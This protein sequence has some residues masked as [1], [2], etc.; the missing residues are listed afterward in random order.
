MLQGDLATFPLAELFQWLDQSRRTGVLEL[1]AGEGPPFWLHVVDRRIV[2]AAGTDAGPEGLGSLARWSH[3]EPLESLWP[4]ACADRIVDLFLGPSAGRFTLVA[5]AAGYDGVRLDLGL[6]QMAL[7]GMRRLDEWPALDRR[8]P[9]DA[10]VLVAD[11]PAA[12]PRTPGQRALLEAAR[13]RASIAEAR[14]ALGL[15]RAAVLR[16]IAALGDLGLAHV[17]GVSAHP[18]PVATLV[19]KAQLLVEARQ[20]DEAAIVFRSLL[21]ADPS[22]RRVR[23]L[24]REAEREQV[25]ALY[26]ELSPVAIP[27]LV[28]GPGALDAPAARRLSAIDREVAGRLNGAWD[29]ASVALAS[30]LREVETLKSLRKLARLGLVELREPR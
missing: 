28:A 27:A 3:S 2:A 17:E 9:L 20:F 4:E 29:V 5:D 11:A 15:S 30:P 1:E 21:S 12:R 16:R 18:D 19:D 8:Y 24:L 7:E 22:D 10:A 13:R 6:L 23:D 25:A 26:R 14:L